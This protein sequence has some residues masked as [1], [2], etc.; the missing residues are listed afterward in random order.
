MGSRGSPLALRQTETAISLLGER[1]VE[2]ELLIVK[3]KG[4]HVLD[5]PLHRVSGRGLF[6]REIDDLMLA[7]EIDVAVHSMKDLP[8]KRPKS[9]VI[10]AVLP[11]DSPFDV[12]V[13]DDG[14]SL[15]DLERG[16]VV[17]TCSMRRASQLRRARP[18]LVIESLRGNLETR[19]RKLGEGKYRAIVLAEAGIERMGYR[20]RYSVL[21]P[22]R[23]VPSANQGAIAVVATR[24]RAEEIVREIDHLSTRLEAECERVIL[25][26]IG[27]SWVV[28]MAA[29]A[30]LKG[31]EL[32]VLAEVLSL[33]GSRFVRVDGRVPAEDHLNGAKKLSREL[34]AKGGRSLAE[35]AVREV[36]T[37]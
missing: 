2:T 25:E 19:L 28:P 13:S 14:V 23:F 31:D 1:G 29:F 8:S 30:R 18:D 5:L 34:V 20:P 21:D 7:G 6:V 3:T 11:R 24:G 17:G 32:R 33:D 36:E 26:A 9:L 12:L 4:D 35:E 16:A 37:V 22:E 10:A 27:G 15:E